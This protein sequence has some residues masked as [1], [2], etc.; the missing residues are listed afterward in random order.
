MYLLGTLNE[1][2][3]SAPVALL[4]KPKE[5]AITILWSTTKYA[6]FSALIFKLKWWLYNVTALQQI[7]LFLCNTKSVGYNF[8]IEK[9]LYVS[10][11]R[12]IMRLQ[13]LSHNYDAL[14]FVCRKQSHPCESACSVWAVSAVSAMV[15]FHPRMKS[16]FLTMSLFKKKKSNDRNKTSWFNR[17]F[18]LK[19]NPMLTFKMT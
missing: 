16:L 19:R 10:M 3:W 2:H 5:T 17:S 1:Q 15:S 18:S 6:G 9:P 11:C 12:I 8:I 7:L 14:A 4:Q 13:H